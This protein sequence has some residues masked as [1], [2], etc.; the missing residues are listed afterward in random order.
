MKQLQDRFEEGK[1]LVEQ[2]LVQEVIE[3]HFVFKVNNY[4]MSIYNIFSLV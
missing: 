2:N 4:N 1:K 3:G